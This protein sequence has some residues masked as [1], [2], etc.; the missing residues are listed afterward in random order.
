MK[1]KIFLPLLAILV[2]GSGLL[3]SRVVQA[4]EGTRPNPFASLVQK[5]ADKFG[6][7]KDEVQEVVDE[8]R[9]E[10]QEEMQQQREE[11][12]AE[13]ETSFEEQLTQ[14]VES[15]EITKEQ[16][17]LI[18]AKR[19]EI[20]ASRQTA[21]EGAEDMTE[22]ERRAA[23]ETERE[24]LETWAEENGID[25]KYLMGG[26]GGKGFGGDGGLRG[27]RPDGEME[28]PSSENATTE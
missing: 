11:R 21:T 5:I 10:H 8:V 7:N 3:M 22:E 27:P 17:Q 28:P 19:E 26:F 6:L 1:K 9:A 13:M 25:M 24:E 23:R 4:E 16:K 15:G 12:Q 14:A 2:V 18:L 20:N